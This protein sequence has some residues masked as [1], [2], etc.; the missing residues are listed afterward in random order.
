MCKF[1][2][3]ELG[4]CTQIQ[5][6]TQQIGCWEAWWWRHQEEQGEILPGGEISGNINDYIN[7]SY[8]QN[9]F[10]DQSLAC[11]ADWLVPSAAAAHCLT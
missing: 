4:Y 2:T 8:F 6:N 10:T 3:D 7:L 9:I 1:G 11:G 5:R